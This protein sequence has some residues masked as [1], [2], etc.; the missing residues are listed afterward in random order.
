MFMTRL[1]A[2]CVLATL[3]VALWSFGVRVATAHSAPVVVLDRDGR[4]TVRH[5]QGL[6][7][8]AVTPGV[9]D[10]RVGRGRLVSRP[11]SER[12]VRSEL[13]RL[14]RHHLITRASY[15]SYAASFNSALA[16]VRRLR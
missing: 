2:P 11:A 4:A 10:G 15:R 6:L 8:P 3:I 7:G 5:D 16:T 1:Q 13:L 9:A 14:Y 12:T